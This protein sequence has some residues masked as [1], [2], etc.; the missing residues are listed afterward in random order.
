VHE[1]YFVQ[2]LKGKSHPIRGH[3]VLEGQQRYSSTWC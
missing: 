1:F 2:P 3:E